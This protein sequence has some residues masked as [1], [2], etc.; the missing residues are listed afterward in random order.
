MVTVAF[1]D[2]RTVGSKVQS[3]A[4]YN[5]RLPI[6]LGCK[7]S[8]QDRARQHYSLAKIID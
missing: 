3:C 8:L 4:I 6:I 5:L 1:V 7:D 2:V